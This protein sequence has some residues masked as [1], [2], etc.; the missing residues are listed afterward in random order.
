MSTLS[1]YRAAYWTDGQSDVVLTSEGESH[2]P[3]ADLMAIAQAELAEQG[4]EMGDGEI[5]IGNYTR[6]R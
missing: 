1:T 3:D 2:L 5:L 6:A 4:G